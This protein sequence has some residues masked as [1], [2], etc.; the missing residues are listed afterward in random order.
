MEKGLFIS[1]LS[2]KESRSAGIYGGSKGTQIQNLLQW[3][4]TF[5]YI[6]L[7]AFQ[8]QIHLIYDLTPYIHYSLI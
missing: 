8:L 1:Y 5:L 7:V 4:I 6:S 2:W 3:K